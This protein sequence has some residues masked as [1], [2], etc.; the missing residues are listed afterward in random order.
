MKNRTASTVASDLLWAKAEEEKAK[1]E[2]LEL[3][4]E[5]LEVIG[6]SEYGTETHNIENYKIKVIAKVSRTV[7][8]Q[9]WA[10]VT[11]N[12]SEDDFPV[13]MNPI[14]IEEKYKVSSPKCREL[15]K[16]RPEL[17]ATLSRAITTTKNKSTITIEKVETE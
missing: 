5:L 14:S 4:R 10:S 16:Y 13:E 17:F 9:M 11:D 7:D 15:Q 2:R 1:Q 3:E 12:L 8:P 6:D